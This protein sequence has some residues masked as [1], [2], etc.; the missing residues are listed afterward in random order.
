MIFEI[1]AV[2]LD[3]G[4]GLEF[5]RFDQTKRASQLPSTGPFSAGVC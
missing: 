1:D 2:E 3:F 5:N 4:K